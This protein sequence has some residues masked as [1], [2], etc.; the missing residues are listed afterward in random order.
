MS[1]SV[2]V[3]WVLGDY[4]IGETLK[5]DN[6]DVWCNRLSYCLWK[7]LS[8]IAFYEAISYL[9]VTKYSTGEVL[10]VYYGQMIINH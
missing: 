5:L 8:I 1:S 10:H 6:D 2:G 3:T 4:H 9:C 7:G